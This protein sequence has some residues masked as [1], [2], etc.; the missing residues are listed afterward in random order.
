MVLKSAIILLCHGELSS[1]WGCCSPLFQVLLE[2][3]SWTGGINPNAAFRPVRAQDVLP[4]VGVCRT[5]ILPQILCLRV[6]AGQAGG[7]FLFCVGLN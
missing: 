2:L 5:V 3:L 1:V 4:A 6:N 7:F